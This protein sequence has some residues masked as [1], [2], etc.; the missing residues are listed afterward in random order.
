LNRCAFLTLDEPGDFVID[1]ER[2][3][4]P[5]ADIGWEVFTLS[6]RQ[7]DIPWESFDAVVIRSTW[8]YWHDVSAFFDKLEDISRRSRL[9]NPIEL[10]RWNLEKTYLRDLQ[11]SGISIVPTMWV[12]HVSAG[13]FAT[14]AGHLAADELVIKPV[15]GANGDDAFRLSPADP[16][17]RLEGIASRFS[18]RDAMVQPFVTRILD[19]GEFSLFF[20]GGEF[21]H[22][23]RKVPAAGEFRSQ[24]ERGAEILRLEPD[25]GLVEA[26]RRAVAA[27]PSLPLYARA[28]LVR[29]SSDD[30]LLMELELIEPSLYLRMDPSAPRRFALALDRWF[31][32]TDSPV[33]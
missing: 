32:R 33:S 27:L 8:D 4:Q 11:S 1:D 23:V 16:A 25:A 2:A 21:S 28:D 7:Q 10:V 30:C 18:G 22:A 14:I 9:A 31:G 6:W 13:D 15:V 26:G 12:R 20:F 17:S 29:G 24:E 5:L 19:E 3:V